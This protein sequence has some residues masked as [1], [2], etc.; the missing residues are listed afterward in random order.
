MTK[1]KT[2]LFYSSSLVVLT[3]FLGGT[4]F[5]TLF[6][7]EYTHY[8][9]YKEIAKPEEFCLLVLPNKMLSSNSAAY[10]SFTYNQSDSDIADSITKHTEL[11]AYS[12]GTFVLILIILS[13][14]YFFNTWIDK[15]KYEK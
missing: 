1:L 15:I 10:Y 14:N 9:D 13:F 3:T 11:R 8:L 12:V 2:L 7:H 4:I 6:S 5:L